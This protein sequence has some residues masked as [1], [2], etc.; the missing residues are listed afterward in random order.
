VGLILKC[1]ITLAL[2]L[3]SRE[4][5][6]RSCLIQFL[7]FLCLSNTHNDMTAKEILLWIY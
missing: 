1:L 3:H 2:D 6:G 5:W 7:N 4:G